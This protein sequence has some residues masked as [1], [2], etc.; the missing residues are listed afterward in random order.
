MQPEDKDGKTPILRRVGVFGGM[1]ILPISWR[2]D[3]M[4]VPP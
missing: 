2:T 4:P 3:E 1:S